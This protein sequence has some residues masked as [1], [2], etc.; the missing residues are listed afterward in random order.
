MEGCPIHDYANISSYSNFNN[1][2]T[3][4]PESIMQGLGN[5]TVIPWLPMITMKE[6]LINHMKDEVVTIKLEDEE[7]NY[8]EGLSNRIITFIDILKTQQ[9]KMDEAEK[10]SKRYSSVYNVY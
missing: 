1:D 3:C 2:I 5:S 9:S 10:E 4:S 8:L 7:E 6:E